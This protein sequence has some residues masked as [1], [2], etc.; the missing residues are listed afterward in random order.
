MNSFVL[1]ILFILISFHVFAQEGESQA[2]SLEQCQF[3]ESRVVLYVPEVIRVVQ[4]SGP[5]AKVLW[6]TMDAIEV[7]PK[8]NTF[9]EGV[10]VYDISEKSEE[11]L[12]CWKYRPELV[13]R[14]KS[15]GADDCVIYTCDYA[16]YKLK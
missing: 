16:R 4:I 12:T 2:E 7:L 8:E 1:S 5:S 13:V 11:D 9:E 3:M 14:G 6:D 15:L 10:K